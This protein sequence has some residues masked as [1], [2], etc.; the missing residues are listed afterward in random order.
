MSAL[1]QI[2]DPI[3]SF[4]RNNHLKFPYGS[5]ACTMCSNV[6]WGESYINISRISPKGYPCIALHW[7]L[8]SPALSIPFSFLLS[9]FSPVNYLRVV[10]PVCGSMS[11]LGVSLKK[12]QNTPRPSEPSKPF[13]M[14]NNTD[15]SARHVLCHYWMNYLCIQN[16]PF[17]PRHLLTCCCCCILHNNRSG[18]NHTQ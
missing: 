8:S 16:D 5:F 1:L 14:A 6:F 18:L 9:P 10:V 11:C 7:L 4:S 13:L 3:I 15:Y 2:F 17:L 12:N